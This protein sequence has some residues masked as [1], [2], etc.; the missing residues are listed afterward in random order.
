MI[1]I[2]QGHERSIALEIFLKS[3]ILLLPPQQKRFTLI[4]NRRTL[5]TN[6]AL[7]DLAGNFEE[8]CV[9]IG[10]NR[11]QCIFFN[12]ERLPESTKA[13]EIALDVI[14][15]KHDLLLT[16]PTSKDQLILNGNKCAGYT[17]YF[18]NY[19]QKNDISMLFYSEQE[20]LLLITDHVP[21]SKLL[22]LL[23]KKLIVDK[24]KTTLLSCEKYFS[25]F[26]EVILAG[27]N[28]HCGENGMLGT[29]DREVFEATDELRAFFPAINFKGPYSADTLHNYQANLQQLFVYMFH[30][31]GL[32]AF[33]AKHGVIGLNISLGMPFLR[34][35]VDHGTAF[36]LY[37]KNRANHLGCS[38]MLQTALNIA[39]KLE[40]SY[41]H[42]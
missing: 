5:E 28:P 32:P 29:E 3:F 35:S 6:L 41:G 22:E 40:L 33:K 38:Y 23:K 1:Y 34:M 9:Y 37:G 20:K 13:L 7:L 15:P 17:E 10:D 27:I 14:D 12:D 8:Q 2:C 11:L 36:E 25:P 24:I 4:V 26:D 31:Q 16:L 42:Q 19:F 30:D 18:R 39:E 21:I